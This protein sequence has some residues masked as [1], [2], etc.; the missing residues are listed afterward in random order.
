MKWQ[1]LEIS[2][3]YEFMNN[4]EY[5]TK[6]IESQTRLKKLNMKLMLTCNIMQV[7]PA[8]KWIRGPPDCI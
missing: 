3:D 1:T 5:E 8:S 2:I 7:A 4:K 6:E